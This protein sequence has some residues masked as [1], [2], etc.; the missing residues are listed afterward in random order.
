M[1]E[2]YWSKDGI[3]VYHASCLDVLPMLPER[4]AG[5]V[6]TDPPYEAEAHTLQR[7]QRGAANGVRVEPIS[8]DAITEDVRQGAAKEIARIADRW[9]LTFCQVEA[10]QTW[11]R[12]YEGHGMTYIRTC[13]WNKPDGSPQFTGDRPGMGYETFVTMHQP[14]RTHWNGG[15]RR[16]VFTHYVEPQRTGARLYQ[17][18]KPFR[19]I[20]ELIELFADPGDLIVDPFGGSMTTALAA[21][22]L[23]FR[24]IAMDISEEACE[25]GVRRLEGASPDRRQLQLQFG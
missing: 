24:C 25:I 18:Q 19:L 8:F 5:L 2:P 13:M 12:C 23:G 21:K 3:T 22:A 10:S 4:C 9:A 7:R 11:R 20:R 14:G 1:L 6:L 15:G 16:G 17:T